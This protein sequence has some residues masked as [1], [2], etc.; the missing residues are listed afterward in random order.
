V[1]L[2]GL[3]VW[4]DNNCHCEDPSED[5][6]QFGNISSLTLLRQLSIHGR[7][8]VADDI[9]GIQHLPQLSRLQLV[10]DALMVSNTSTLTWSSLTALQDLDLRH[11]TMQAEALQ[12]LTQLQA[13]SLQSCGTSK[14]MQELLDAVSHMTLLTQLTFAVSTSRDL[15]QSHPPAAAAFTALTASTRLCSL[16]FGKWGRG[17]PQAW[18]LFNPSRV[19]PHLREVQLPYELSREDASMRLGHQQLQHM[20]NCCLNVNSLKLSLCDH[21]PTAA[22]LSLLQLSALTR[23]EV[24]QVG[25]AAGEVLVD[26]AAQLTGL[27]CL[28]LKGHIRLDPTVL[29]LTV[30]KALNHFDVGEAYLNNKV[31]SKLESVQVWP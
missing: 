27:K 4:Y 18:D 7:D 31:S 13:L 9:T 8:L 22:L 3:D 17:V 28:R 6:A 16:E 15:M 19:H 21:P 25:A 14:P 1:N 20:C 23:L 26:V 29:Q 2:T 10:S 5:V 30:L 24:H 11:C 12:A